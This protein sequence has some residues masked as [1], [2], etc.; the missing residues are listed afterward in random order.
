MLKKL[1]NDNRSDKN[2][3]HS[4]LEV[5]ELFVQ[6]IK[7]S[8]TN[9]MEIGIWAGGGILMFRDYFP[10]ATIYGLDIITPE[11][12]EPDLK[13]AARIKLLLSMDAYTP[14]LINLFKASGKKFDMI[15]DDGPHTL[16]SMLFFVKHYSTLLTNDGILVVE[17]IT[18]Y[19]WTQKMLQEL[20]PS[21]VKST[22]I[23][24]R[25]HVNGRYDDIILIVD[26]GRSH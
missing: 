12:V 22:F 11:Q 24:D 20:P 7:D 1:M 26:K 5:Y 17:D 6:R 9:V 3:T 19:E 25:R 13:E 2:T 4:Y 14:E 10:N 18:D 16:E 8:A 23:I 15:V 21:L